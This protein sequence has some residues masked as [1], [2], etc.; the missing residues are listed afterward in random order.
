L[1]VPLSL[2]KEIVSLH[3]RGSTL[4]FVAGDSSPALPGAKCI[5]SCLPDFLA[6][7]RLGQL[8]TCG[9]A[10]ASLQSVGKLTM[11]PD[12]KTSEKC[13]THNIQAS[14]A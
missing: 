1:F 2:A 10:L 8:S 12:R 4:P 3:S 6:N 9:P 11:S 7:A 13:N 14:E 5:L